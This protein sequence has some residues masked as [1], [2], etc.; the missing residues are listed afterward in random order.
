[1]D[2]A[3]IYLQYSFKSVVGFECIK[4]TR[5]NGKF[6]KKKIIYTDYSDMINLVQSNNLT[7]IY[8]VFG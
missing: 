6:T 3:Y 2:C 4:K 5:N 1:M 7:R 8:S